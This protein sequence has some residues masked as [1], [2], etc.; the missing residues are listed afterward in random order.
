MFANF[1]K[2]LVEFIAG[3]PLTLTCSYYGHQSESM[4]GPGAQPR[5]GT[6]GW[7]K[8]EEKKFRQIFF[9]KNVLTFF[10]KNIFLYF[11][12]LLKIFFSS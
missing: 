3:M 12:F 11:F 4:R 5:W 8:I 7:K 6:E 2:N 9:S 10:Q 1:S